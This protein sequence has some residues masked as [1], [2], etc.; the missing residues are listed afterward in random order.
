G[1]GGA[2]RPNLLLDEMRQSIPAPVT[3][4]DTDGDLYADRM[5]A[6][7]MGGR[8]WRF[9]IWNGNSP[10]MLVTGGVFADLG[11][12]QE[13][14]PTIENTRRFYYAPDVALIQRRGAD[15]YFSIAIGSGYRGHPLHTATRDR[16]YSLRDKEPFSRLP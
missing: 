13:N 3:V 2:R 4:I 8:I 10:D 6:A 12:A 16:F 5:Y 11:A 9:D 15:P 1:P 14:P 7:D